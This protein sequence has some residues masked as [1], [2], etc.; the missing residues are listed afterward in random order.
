MEKIRL[1]TEPEAG[2]SLYFHDCTVLPGSLKLCG[3]KL[4]T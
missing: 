2:R 3:A 4:S 1:I